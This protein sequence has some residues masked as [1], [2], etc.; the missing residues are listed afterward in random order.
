MISSTGNLKAS[1]ES[2]LIS[3]VVAG[4]FGGTLEESLNGGGMLNSIVEF[5][6]RS[7]VGQNQVVLRY[8]IIHCPT[9]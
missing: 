4:V 3:A 6:D 1:A 7:T 5:A 9:S 2:A 8:V